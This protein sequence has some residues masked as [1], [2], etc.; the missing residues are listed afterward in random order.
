MH[1]GL[2]FW[3]LEKKQD[4]GF[5]VSSIKKVLKVNSWNWE[6]IVPPESWTSV[7]KTPDNL[8][9][10]SQNVNLMA[11]AIFTQAL[12]CN[13]LCIYMYVLYVW[14]TFRVLLNLFNRLSL[15]KL[16]ILIFWMGTPEHKL[17]CF[18]G[19]S[20]AIKK[21]LYMKPSPCE[22]Q[23]RQSKAAVYYCKWSKAGG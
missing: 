16:S 12:S 23:L 15:S 2:T 11:M 18:R 3:L 21:Q 8:P 13:K 5:N 9:S 17:N 7:K 10:I 14:T 6:T 1:F 19:E 22:K 20:Y 4:W